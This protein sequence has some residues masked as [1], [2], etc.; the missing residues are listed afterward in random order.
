MTEAGVC[1]EDRRAATLSLLP[2]K[3]L[4]AKFVANP[5]ARPTTRRKNLTLDGAKLNTLGSALYGNG[6]FKE[7]IAA[8]K[9]LTE[10]AASNLF[11][12]V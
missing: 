11:H 6:R 9:T 8:L 3:F 5:A 7:A 2:A 1:F 10:Q 4:P 12:Q